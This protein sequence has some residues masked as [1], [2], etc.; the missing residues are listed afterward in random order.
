VGGT[1]VGGG[2]TGV[3]VGAGAHAAI[4]VSIIAKAMTNKTCFFIFSSPRF[5]NWMLE[6]GN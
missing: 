6:I 1:G 5:G 3:G 4:A 2:G